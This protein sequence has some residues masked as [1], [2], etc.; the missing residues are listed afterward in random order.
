MRRLLTVCLLGMAVL[1]VFPQ[2][3]WAS[4]SKCKYSGIRCNQDGCYATGG[5]QDAPFG[6]PSKIGCEDV[7]G[8]CQL[9]GDA[10]LWALSPLTGEVDAADDAQESS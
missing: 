9:S 4:C 10:C 5:C 2:D 6:Q 8:V 3:V 7:N 1:S